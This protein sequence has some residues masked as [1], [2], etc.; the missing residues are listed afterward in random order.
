MIELS[1]LD[2]RKKKEDF[3]R[4]FRGY[5]D[6]QVDSFLDVVADRLE[7]LVSEQRRL[8]D[9][10]SSLEEKLSDFRE[11]ERALN[12]ALLA[13]QELREEA[14][15]QAERDA[16]LRVREAES[17]AEDIIGE[18]HQ[19]ARE[20]RNEIQQLRRKREQL[21]HS[22][23]AVLRRFREELEAEEARMEEEGEPGDERA[24]VD[25]PAAAAAGRPETSRGDEG[26][27]AEPRAPAGSDLA[28]QGDADGAGD[29]LDEDELSLLPEDE[30]DEEGGRAPAAGRDRDAG[31]EGGGG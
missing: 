2:V 30:P 9:R 20:A 22:L 16:E 3:D 7:G 1:P 19:R 14:R 17:R 25:G 29:E 11:R 13:A 24:G 8:R 26:P 15:S 21:L 12:E 10:V 28:A 23:R 18:A 31:R 27:D 4:S 6:G 5:D